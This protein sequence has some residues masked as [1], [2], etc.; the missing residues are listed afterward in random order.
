MGRKANF[1][2]HDSSRSWYTSSMASAQHDGFR[3]TGSIERGNSLG[4][5][6]TVTRQSRLYRQ[7]E[8]GNQLKALWGQEHL[9]WDVNKKQGVFEGHGVHDERTNADT[10]GFGIKLQTSTNSMTGKEN[11]NVSSSSAAAAGSSSATCTSSP[12]FTAKAMEDD[13][14]SP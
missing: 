13:K 10:V 12:S 14:V 7:N 1:P 6:K 9:C 8:S 2:P 4:S 11:S 5:S 3:A